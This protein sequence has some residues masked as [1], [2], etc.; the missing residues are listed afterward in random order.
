MSKINDGLYSSESQC[1][2]TPP[3]IPQALLRLHDREAFDLDPATTEFNIPSL[4]ACRLDGEYQRQDD[5]WVKVGTGHGLEA[6][7]SGLVFFNPPYS[8]SQDFLKKACEEARK[9]AR[10]WGLLPARTETIYQHEH[11]LA[12]AGFTIFIKG[13]VN[14]IPDEPTREKLIQKWIDKQLAKGTFPG[15]KQGQATL[16]EPEP[17]LLRTMAEKAVDEGTAPFP[18]MLLYWG[19]D[20]REIL[21]KWQESPPIPGTP[22]ARATDLLRV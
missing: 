11:G 3:E 20:Y 13:R 22:M 5:Q 8:H 19:R 6:S 14:F 12:Q 10:I 2:M 4:R 1:W 16:F 17:E 7:W 18:T 21:A 15:M 9:G